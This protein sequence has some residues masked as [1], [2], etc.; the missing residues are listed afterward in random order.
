MKVKDR[1]SN[2]VG[3]IRNYSYLLIKLSFCCLQS[4]KNHLHCKCLDEKW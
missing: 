1:T 4:R 3:V 2:Y